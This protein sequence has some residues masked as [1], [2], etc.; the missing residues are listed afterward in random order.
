MRYVNSVIRQLLLKLSDPALEFLYFLLP[1]FPCVILIEGLVNIKILT[2]FPRNESMRLV[3]F[4]L[5]ILCLKSELHDFLFILRTII[6]FTVFD[7]GLIKWPDG[8]LLF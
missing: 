4:S 5:K 8:I 3:Q 6:T 1:A 7:L 2:N